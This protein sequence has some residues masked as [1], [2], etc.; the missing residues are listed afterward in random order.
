M[1]NFADMETITKTLKQR[2]RDRGLRYNWVAEQIGV[3]KSLLS[4]YLSGTTPMPDHINNKII[5]LLRQ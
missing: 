1:F 5:D 4:Q 2:I 3:S